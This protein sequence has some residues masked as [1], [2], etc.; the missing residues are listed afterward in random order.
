MAMLTATYIHAQQNI[1][2][3]V[4]AMRTAEAKHYQAL[5]GFEPTGAG[6]HN[7]LKRIRKMYVMLRIFYFKCLKYTPQYKVTYLYF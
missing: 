7:I 2:F 4:E 6:T 3:D 5:E 1:A